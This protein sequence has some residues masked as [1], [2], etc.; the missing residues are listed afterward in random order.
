MKNENGKTDSLSRRSL[1]GQAVGVAGGEGQ[2]AV[3][4]TVDALGVIAGHDAGIHVHA[5]P[6]VRMGAG[7]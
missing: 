1:L 4:L 7:D 6:H 3:N 5:D 2:D